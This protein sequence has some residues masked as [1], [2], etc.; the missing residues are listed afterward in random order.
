M[1]ITRIRRA[2]RH[3]RTAG[4]CFLQPA[5][6]VWLVGVWLLLWGRVTPGL[7]ASGVVIAGLAMSLFP[8]P[9]LEIRG[10]PRPLFVI[11]FFA[12][13]VY[14]VV[15]AS[16]H[17]AWMAVRPGPEPPCA[18]IGVDLHTKSDLML[19]LVGEVL[20]LVPGSLVVEVDRASTILYLH[21]IG[22]EGPEDVERERSRAAAVEARMIRAFGS[23]GDRLRLEQDVRG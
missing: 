10:R 13:F 20:S 21:V 11:A 18:V 4:Q 17:V 16:V 3:A 7:I 1:P 19:T 14:D 5:T 9:A 15:V 8:M 6:A 2:R 22:V 12:R 23:P